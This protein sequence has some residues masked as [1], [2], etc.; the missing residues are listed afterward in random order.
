MYWI[1]VL[2]NKEQ[3]GQTYAEAILNYCAEKGNFPLVEIF[4]RQEMFFAQT[5]NTVPDLV[6]LALKGV[7]GLNVAEHLRSLYPECGII[8]CSDLDF[9]LH[10]FRL[11]IEYFFMEPA[12]A[13]KIWEGL[14]VWLQSRNMKKTINKTDFRR[15]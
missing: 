11:R 7:A 3:E 1:T 15:K 14:T 6:F 8:W 12:D 10:A 9:S 2:A 5:Q 4:Q 13:S